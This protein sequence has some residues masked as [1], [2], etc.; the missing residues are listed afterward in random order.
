ML[1]ETLPCAGLDCYSPFGS[2]ETA[3]TIQQSPLQ[4]TDRLA[5]FDFERHNAEVKQLWEG[6]NAGKPA[7]TPV[8]FGIN[9]RYFMANPAVNTEGLE[10]KRYSQDPDLMFDTQLR[11]Q[12][13]KQFNLLMDV[14]LGL[15]E[16]WQVYV[17][18]QNYSEAAWMGCP[19]EYREGQVPDT[20][21]A[22]MD[23]PERV[24]EQGIPDPFSGL[25]ARGLETYEHMRERAG[26]ETYFGRPIEV[27]PPFIGSDGVMTVACNL[28]GPEF[29]C[30]TMAA[31]PERL[32]R[33]F[34]FITE[35]TI[36]RMI[37][38]RLLTGI[39]VPQ[40]RFG[41]ADDSI[42][43]IST[44]MYRDHVLPYHRRVYKAL[45]TDGPCGIHL[46]GDATR[47]FRTLFEELDVD[48]FDTGFPVNFERLRSELGPDVRIWGGPHVE[49]LR[50]ASPLEVR[51]EARRILQSGVLD[52][53][54]FVLREGNNLAPGT[55]LENTESL[56][57]A[58]RDFGYP[59][60]LH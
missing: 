55:P 27:L 18:F 1:S 59:A 31:D 23:A 8:I 56:Y 20:V 41:Y 3:M 38:W 42:A 10:F 44:A 58:G 25:L 57:H 26:Q 34:D 33:L 45:S 4:P 22:F 51:E 40:E 48:T 32:H 6:F 37:A 47:H 16:K 29:V 14:E 36:A 17:D 35:A 53:G 52:G 15:P 9:T 43:L 60:G 13:W 24:M 30:T 54:M 5:G 39:P 12:R 28:F 49:L 46:C 21:P 50:N 7:R 11:F 19:I 2:V